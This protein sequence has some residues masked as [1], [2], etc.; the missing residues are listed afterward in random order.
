MSRLPKAALKKSI[1]L[2][3]HPLFQ[4]DE[5]FNMPQS[6]NK[7]FERGAQMH[8]RFLL[9]QQMQLPDLTLQLL[10]LFGCAVLEQ[11]G[12]SRFEVMLVQGWQCTVVCFHEI[13]FYESL[14]KYHLKLKI[15]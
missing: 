7:S 14:I 6:I 4:T 5:Y 13:L 10:G 15:D 12:G 1:N 11:E 9:Q 8:E 3:S 2:E